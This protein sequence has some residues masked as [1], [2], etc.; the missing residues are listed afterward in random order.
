M[1]SVKNVVLLQILFSPAAVPKYCVRLYFLGL[2]QYLS[3]Q[4]SYIIFKNYWLQC[5]PAA[6][7]ARGL[8]MP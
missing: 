6:V 8:P 1:L 3:K 2:L 4:A 5:G 7:R